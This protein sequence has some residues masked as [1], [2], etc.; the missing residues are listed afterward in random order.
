MNLEKAI[1][2]FEKSAKKIISKDL[3]KKSA[4]AVSPKIFEC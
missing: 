1:T 4:K 3:G 2:Q